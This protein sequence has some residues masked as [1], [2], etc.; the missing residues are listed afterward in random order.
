M[1][2]YLNYIL[3]LIIFWI[4]LFFFQRL[5]FIVF[6]TAHYDCVNFSNL[7]LCNWYSLGLDISM[8][9]YFLSLPVILLAVFNYNG[10]KIIRRILFIYFT[11]FIISSSLILIFDIGL[12]A[13][14]G[15]KI[16]GKALSYLAYPKEAIGTVGSSPV[17]LLLIVFVVLSF[18]SIWVFKKF[19]H[20][21]LVKFKFNIFLKIFLPVILLG[22]LLIGARGGLQ[23]HPINKRWSYFSRY[24][25]LNQA[26]VNS[27][28]NFVE[29]AT[30]PDLVKENPYNYF[31]DD[32]AIKIVKET[33]KTSRD[34]TTYLFKINKPNIVMILLESWSAEVTGVYGNNKNA[35]PQFDELSKEGYLFTNYYSTG[36]RTEQGFAALISGFPSQPTTTIIRKFGK[37][38]NLPSIAQTLDSNAYHSSYY[39]GGNLEFA[40]TKAYMESAGFDKFIGQDDFKYKNRTHWGAYDAEL[41]DFTVTDLKNNPEPFLSIIMTSTNHEPFDFPIDMGFLKTNKYYNTVRY[42]DK[43]LGDFIA[44]SK[45]EQWYKNTIFII[46][47]DHAHHNPM[48]R[49]NYEIKRHWIP[50][51]IYGEPLKDEYKGQNCDIITCHSD[52]PAILLSQLK[53]KHNHFHWSKNIFNKYSPEFAFYSFDDGFGWINPKQVLIYDHKLGDTVFVKNNNIPLKE[54]ELY[55]KQGK[56]YLQLLVKEYIEFNN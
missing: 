33:F 37:F 36:F 7:M 8:T 28:W 34:S 47:A 19:V 6:Q 27:V 46:V 31:D 49:K 53:L 42:T 2:K 23:S 11:I 12:F 41:F 30:K 22:L 54:N 26:A 39:Y 44:K 17:L 15:S 14:W 10:R 45:N 35:T 20:K 24:S 5:I 48:G 4:V 55:L 25:V 32:E 56:A 9:S 38:E 51:L 43:S 50:F 29:V 18:L 52:F 40:N 21:H 3:R 1:F 13:E 16:N